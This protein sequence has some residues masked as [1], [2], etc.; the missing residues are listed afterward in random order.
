M[1]FLYRSVV[2]KEPPQQAH[3]AM[4]RVWSPDGPWRAL[5]Q[6]QLRRRGIAYELL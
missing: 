4:A 6:G 1:V 2:L 3:E 5:L